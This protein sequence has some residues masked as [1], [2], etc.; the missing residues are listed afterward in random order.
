M[1]T[2]K[3]YYTF[4]SVVLKNIGLGTLPSNALFCAE[5]EKKAREMATERLKRVRNP[6]GVYHELVS[7][8]KIEEYNGPS[9]SDLLTEEEIEKLEKGEME[10]GIVNDKGVLYRKVE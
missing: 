5:N 4:T 8:D 1:K 9:V 2:Y 6:A 10:E 7:I 3:V